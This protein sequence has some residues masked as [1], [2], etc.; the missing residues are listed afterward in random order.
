MKK[1]SNLLYI[2]LGQDK[3]IS[4]SLTWKKKHVYF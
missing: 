1:S 4:E 3:K 2:S